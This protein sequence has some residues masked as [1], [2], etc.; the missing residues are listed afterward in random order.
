MTAFL[1]D[2]QTLIKRAKALIE[3][4]IKH[5]GVKGN[6]QQER[7]ANKFAVAYAAGVIA[8]DSALRLGIRRTLEAVL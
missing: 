3:A 8:A 5:V 2:R 7:F 6:A 1:E 4:F